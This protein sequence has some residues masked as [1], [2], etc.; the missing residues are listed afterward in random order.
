[1]GTAQHRF[2]FPVLARSVVQS[3][4]HI[5]YF[6]HFS[7]PRSDSATFLAVEQCRIANGDTSISYWSPFVP[8]VGSHALCSAADLT[9]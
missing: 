6:G 4:A 7:G 9:P 5:A 1:M 3:H 2:E 8:L